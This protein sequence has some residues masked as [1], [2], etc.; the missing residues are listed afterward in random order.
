MIAYE[1][2]NP[3]TGKF[4]TALVNEKEIEEAQDFFVQD[5]EAYQAE[6]DIIETIMQMHINNKVHPKLNNLD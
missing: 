3:R 1:V 2:F 5:Y 6:K 4:E